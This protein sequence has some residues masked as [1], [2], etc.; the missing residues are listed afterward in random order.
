MGNMSNIE[1]NFLDSFHA[2]TITVQNVISQL[3]TDLKK[4][5]LPDQEREEIVISLDEALTNAIQETICKNEGA[6]SSDSPF[7]DIT[8]R[9][10]ITAKEFDATIIDHGK[11]L[12]IQK[13][14]TTI[15]DSNAHNY[16]GQIYDYIDVKSQTK[17][18]VRLNGQEIQ[19]NGIG[20][21]LKI[22]LSFMDLV[23]IDL[24]DKKNI[25]SDSVSEFTDGT[26]LNMKRKRRYSENG[27][28]KAIV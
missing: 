5:Q 13:M 22:L 15:P 21:G 8:V 17:F 20:A 2:D 11:G 18:Q 12:D 6:C 24:I 25:L 28:S 9:Y 19:L 27:K 10:H 16:E 7:H 23:S 4:M 14:M 26:I 3:I 1:I